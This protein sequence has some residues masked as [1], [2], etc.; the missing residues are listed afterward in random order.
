MVNL[1][2]LHILH[3]YVYTSDDDSVDNNSDNN[4]DSDSI[5]DV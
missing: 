2:N 1:P 3:D 4:N 5:S